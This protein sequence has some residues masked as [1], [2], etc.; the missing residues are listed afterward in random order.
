[1]SFNINLTTFN[2]ERMKK[3]NKK[4]EIGVQNSDELS[5]NISRAFRTSRDLDIMLRSL[6]ELVTDTFRR[7]FFTVMKILRRL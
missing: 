6:N 2:R 4:N 3:K 7:V 5:V 1:M